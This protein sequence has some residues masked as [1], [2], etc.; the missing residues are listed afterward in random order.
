VP[1]EVKH[2]TASLV[3]ERPRRGWRGVAGI[4]AMLNGYLA[5][6][7]GDGI[8]RDDEEPATVLAAE[9]RRGRRR[10]CMRRGSSMS[11]G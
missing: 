3:L 5:Q 7:K 9:S 11:T 1:V 6:Q 4:M 10:W 8:T 2:G